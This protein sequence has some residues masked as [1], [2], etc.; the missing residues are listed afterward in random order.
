MIWLVLRVVLFVSV[1]A[2]ISGAASL[3]VDTRGAVSIV[4]DGYEYPPLS[5][6]EFV[7][8]VLVTMLALWLLYKLAGLLVAVLRFALGD[9]TALS[10]YWSR[11][12]E[13]RGFAALARAQVALAEGDLSAAATHA[14]K[15]TRMLGQRDLTDLLG[16]QIAEAR[17]DVTEARRRYRA[18]A[19]EPPT[20]MVGVK[21]L[22]A[23]A[24]K[25]G[26]DER[27]LKFAEHAFSLRPRDPQVQQTLFD[28]Q[29]K[30]GGWEGALRTLTA[31][32]RN[33][34][35]PREVLDR[36]QAV[37]NLE[38]AAAAHRSGDARTAIEAADAAV[39]AAPG[40]APAAAFAARLHSGKGDPARAGR[41]LR[42][43]WKLSP[44]PDLAQAFAEIAPDETATERRRR[45]RDLMAGNP[46][47]DETK[48]LGAELAIADADWSAARKALGSLPSDKPTHRSLAMM[49]AVEKGEGSADSIVRGYLARAV[50]APRG[51]HWVCDRCGAAPGAWS[52]VC[53]SCGGFDTMA[54]RE[55]AE[56]SEAV[57]ASMLPLIVGDDDQAAGGHDDDR[58][59]EE[60]AREAVRE[61]AGTRR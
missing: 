61:S 24:V 39:K 48:F 9:E 43:A 22:L 7:G 19:K 54:W 10:R 15:A 29:V 50:T 58:L 13:R 28:L 21:G 26:E 14:R 11:A 37:V 35:L 30:R 3:L 1:V 57:S 46:D 47:H 27:A 56:A 4:W 5:L 55:T 52:A 16:A 18:L 49:A 25:Q 53:P 6:V 23:Q 34:T 33:K 40:L 44:Q 31:M 59:D 8:A 32:A 12:K 41:I 51:A 2:A 45:F 60:A 20:A 36:R 42:D 38:R 17:G